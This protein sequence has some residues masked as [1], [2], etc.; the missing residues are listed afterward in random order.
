M[1]LIMAII[2]PDRLDAVREALSE[3]GITGMTVGE[4]H[5]YG[6]QQGHTEIYR[7]AEYD[8][9]FVPKVKIEVALPASLTAQA[10]ETI[11]RTA[12]SGKIGDGKI[13]VVDL[14]EVLRIRTGESGPD[15]L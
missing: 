2:K 3:V 12:Q 11:Q 14:K 9:A 13:F 10:V 6:R 7:G 1:Q 4:V 8:V 5:G 15:A